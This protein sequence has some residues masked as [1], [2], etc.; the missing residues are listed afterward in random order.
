MTPDIPAIL[1]SVAVPLAYIYLQVHIQSRQVDTS[2]FTKG[3]Y[4]ELEYQTLDQSVRHRDHMIGLSGSIFVALSLFLIGNLFR[5]REDGRVTA[6]FAS[7]MIFSIW[8]FFIQLGDNRMMKRTYD[9]LQWIEEQL[10]FEAHR[11]L[12]KQ[13]DRMKRW[14]WFVVLCM[15]LAFGNMLM[16]QPV[17]V[18]W[19]SVIIVVVLVFSHLKW[20]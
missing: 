14:A 5:L 9:R 20:I 16:D 6:I 8:L 18:I 13:R 17:L 4:L 3:K 19:S 15:L 2:T 10:G 11:Y 1:F 7:W 12:E